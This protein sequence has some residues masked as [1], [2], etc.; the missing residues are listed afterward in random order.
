MNDI[1][2]S[3][4]DSS[5]IEYSELKPLEQLD[6]FKKLVLISLDDFRLMYISL[7]PNNDNSTNNY[8][9]S[10]FDKYK[11]AMSK[12]YEYIIKLNSMLSIIKITDPSQTNK[13]KYEDCEQILGNTTTFLNVFNDIG[14]EY[15]KNIDLMIEQ[16]ESYKFGQ[17]ITYEIFFKIDKI[18]KNKKEF[19][20]CKSINTFNHIINQYVIQLCKINLIL[21]N[22]Y[23][24]N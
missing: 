15:Q 10:V 2:I 3:K 7:D 17:S 22:I 16:C 21:K 20:L 11:L 18:L 23:I 6:N 4:I 12:G 9:Q 1:L 19:A 5:I 13:Y 14:I 24:N 8:E